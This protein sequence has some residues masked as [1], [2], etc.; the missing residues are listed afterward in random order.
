MTLRVRSSMRHQ[1]RSG[2]DVGGIGPRIAEPDKIFPVEVAEG[3]S[4]C[5]K[6]RGRLTHQTVRQDAAAHRAGAGSGD[7][8]ARQ[9][10]VLLDFRRAVLA[11]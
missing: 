2:F 9:E 1:C 10:E 3:W 8:A 5:S 6:L 4:S 11:M 7:Q